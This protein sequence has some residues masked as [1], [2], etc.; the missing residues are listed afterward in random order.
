MVEVAINHFEILQPPRTTAY[1]TVLPKLE[2]VVV[3]Y[4]YLLHFV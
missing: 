3:G 4:L 1:Y 2:A